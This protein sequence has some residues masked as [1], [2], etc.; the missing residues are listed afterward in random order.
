MRYVF[1][2]SDDDLKSRV[3]QINGV[4]KEELDVSSFVVDYD[5]DIL[6]NF[7]RQLLSCKD[8]RFLIV[9]DYDCD[10]ICSTLIIKKLLDDLGI[11]N[12]YYIPS[13]LKEGYGISRKIVDTAHEHG[14]DVLFCVD[15]G[16]SAYDVLEYARSLGLISFVIDHHE[17]SDDPCAD[18][19][20]HPC[21]FDRKY[22]DM[23][24]SGLSCLFSNSIRAD[25]L[26]SVYGGLGTLADMVKVLGYNRYLLKKMR[27]ILRKKTVY[28]IAYLSRNRDFDY[29]TLSFDVIP[30]INAVSRLDEM[31]NVN[32]VV[33]YLIDD[34]PECRKYLNRIEEINTLRKDLSRQMSSLAERICDQSSD[35]VIVRSAQFKEGLCGL[36]ANRM[37][38]D[39]GKPVLVLAEKDGM[40][41]GSGRAPK[42]SDLFSYLEKAKDLF[43]T[44]GGHAQ[45]VGL[46][47][48]DSVYSDFLIYVGSNHF[49]V[50]QLEKDVLCVD[51]DGIS[52]DMLDELDE[53][54][55]FGNGFEEPLLCIKDA[56]YVRKF[57]I[58]AA[59]PKFVMN[60]VLDA[61]SFDPRHKDAVFD[62][63]IGHLKK[64]SYHPNKLSF[65]IEDLI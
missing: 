11:A 56:S 61:I 48:N 58:S 10:G 19:W 53:L 20:L 50:S 55:P 41:K 30:K 2:D 27:D 22:D 8:K 5:L 6:K 59:Y 51:K 25:E 43:E 9:G 16:I 54:K 65:V 34:S 1:H 32:Y 21:L 12:N 4:D 3:C 60:D 45:A 18:H 33:K 14:F 36:I 46:S 52:F 13:R 37:M 62:Q 7:R 38:F 57:L 29:D 28:P 31:M 15:N 26:S 40:L 24:A 64:D 39:L 17:F 49:E 47:M 23:C 35:I 63:M 44:F 42:G